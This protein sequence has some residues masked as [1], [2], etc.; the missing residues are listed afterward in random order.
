MS[1]IQDV[2]RRRELSNRVSR[3]ASLVDLRLRELEAKL[4]NFDGDPPFE[5]TVSLVPNVG[6]VQ[7]F[8]VYDF[9]Y[10]LGAT[11]KAERPLFSINLT[12]SLVFKLKEEVPR[13]ELL[14]FGEIG[15]VEI[16]H[17]YVREIVHNL[18]F[19]MGLPPF[20]LDVAPPVEGKVQT[21][22]D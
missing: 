5:P 12:M 21:A 6:S 4:L 7:K 19:R 15:V 1:E 20:V 8:A 14:A 3:I 18:T 13:E 22:A 17:P 16:A 2:A 10:T 9:A 11:D